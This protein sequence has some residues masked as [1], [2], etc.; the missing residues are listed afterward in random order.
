VV[1]KVLAEWTRLFML[2]CFLIHDSIPVQSR[3]SFA[4]LASRTHV[5][6]A[7]MESLCYDTNLSDFAII[8]DLSVTAWDRL[9]GVRVQILTI[10]P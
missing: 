4:D 6:K 5:W 3:L 7:I 2:R 1:G 9:K 10:R 8:E